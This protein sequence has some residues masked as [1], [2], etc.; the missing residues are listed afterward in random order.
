MSVLANKFGGVIFH[1]A[2]H[3]L[4]T[5]QIERGTTPFKIN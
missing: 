3:L 1:E 4:E 2:R 5:T